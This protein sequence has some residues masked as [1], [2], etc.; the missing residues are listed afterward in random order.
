M[1]ASLE[2]C[3]VAGIRLRVEGTD[4]LCDAPQGALTPE[5]V[6][7]LKAHKAEILAALTP[8]WRV[9]IT[10]PGG[11]TF[12]VDTP[13]GWT[14]PEWQAYAFRY[15]GPGCAVTAIAGLPSPRA[16]APIDEALAGACDGMTGITAAEMRSLL[17]PEDIADIDGGEIPAAPTLRTYAQSFAEG[18]RSGRIEVLRGTRGLGGIA[19]RHLPEIRG[20]GT[21]CSTEPRRYHAVD[22]QWW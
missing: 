11:R 21:T 8:W 19:V 16:P 9:S 18:I 15:H 6:A 5:L 17:S 13:S 10:E 14:L 12:E 4:L 3:R 20:V 7:D 1:N 22:R 2:R